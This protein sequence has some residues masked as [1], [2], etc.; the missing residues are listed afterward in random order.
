VHHELLANEEEQVFDR[1]LELT[2]MPGLRPSARAGTTV[3]EL[4][5]VVLTIGFDL[6]RLT[7]EQICELL[8]EGKDLRKFRQT[9]GGFA[10]R[11]PH[12]LD[13]E[14]G[15]VD[16]AKRRR[17]CSTSGPAIRATCRRLQKSH[18]ST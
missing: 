8:K 11:I 4:A 2:A 16:C 15:S 12:G 17:P 5:H 6:T 10:A 18:S 13:D 3:E 14:D 7:P 9:L 1:L